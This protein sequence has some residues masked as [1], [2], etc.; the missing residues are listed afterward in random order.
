[1]K[2]RYIQIVS[3]LIS[4]TLM[5]QGIVWAS[6]YAN[7]S[8]RQLAFGERL[9]Q[10]EVLRPGE[11]VSIRY[12]GPIAVVLSVGEGEIEQGAKRLQ[13]LR[14][15]NVPNCW[16]VKRYLDPDNGFYIFDTDNLYLL[17]PETMR[18]SPEFKTLRD[19]EE[20]IIGR[21]DAGRFILEKN[22]SRRHVK[23]TR[24]GEVFRIE[25]LGS[26]NGTSRP[27]F[28]QEPPE[29]AVTRNAR[30]VINFSRRLPQEGGISGGIMGLMDKD[31]QISFLGN[32]LND[33]NLR[34]EARKGKLF[35]FIFSRAHFQESPDE[36]GSVSY[37][38]VSVSQPSRRK[39]P[40][41]ALRTLAASLD[42]ASDL[43]TGSLRPDAVLFEQVR[44][45]LVR[46]RQVMASGVG[47]NNVEEA[48][49][50]LKAASAQIADISGIAAVADEVLIKIYQGQAPREISLKNLAA[51]ING[52]IDFIRDKIGAVEVSMDTDEGV[53]MPTANGTLEHMRN[54]KHVLEQ[55]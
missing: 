44:T 37:M 47:I 46:L 6:P 48:V 25:D 17:D 36:K 24:S 11:A 10:R 51:L 3:I 4:S 18:L 40:L 23:I 35:A 45:N 30:T 1:M 42:T 8:L 13:I 5:W 32:F 14:Y 38:L 27:I 7:F 9:R 28:S 39:P 33:A 50:L 41:A 20:Y 21:E 15:D 52:R 22:I 31:G 53:D 19:G 34:R 29:E 55:I 26:R 2:N 49:Y 54:P 12:K 16:P 43:D